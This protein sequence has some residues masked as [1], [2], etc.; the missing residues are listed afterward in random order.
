MLASTT[1]IT[2]NYDGNVDNNG[3]QCFQC[4]GGALHG[5]RTWDGA[6]AFH[7]LRARA[8]A[9]CREGLQP[10]KEGE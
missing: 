3:E 6:P 10:G 8:K 9:L 4:A 5:V 7:K 2:I 1:Q